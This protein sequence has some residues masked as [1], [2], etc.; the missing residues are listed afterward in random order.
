MERNLLRQKELREVLYLIMTL[1][2]S[3]NIQLPLQILEA[4]HIR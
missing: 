1:Q 4:E 2:Q 3:E